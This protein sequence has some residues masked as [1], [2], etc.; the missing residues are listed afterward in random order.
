MLTYFDDFMAFSKR[1]MKQIKVD[2]PFC[3][4]KFM[5]NS[6]CE[7]ILHEK[8]MV[9]DEEDETGKLILVF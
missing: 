6:Y 3:M 2:K 9:N 8:F 4:L 1:Y 5:V 7:A